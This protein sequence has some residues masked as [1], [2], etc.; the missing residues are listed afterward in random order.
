MESIKDLWD[1][2]SWRLA[3]ICICVAAIL[4]VA[5]FYFESFYLRLMGIVAICVN[6]PYIVIRPFVKYETKL[7]KL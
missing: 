6:L 7:N 1:E 4:V 3:I 2:D 5:G